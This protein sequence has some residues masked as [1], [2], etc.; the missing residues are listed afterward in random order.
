MD[1]IKAY[2]FIIDMQEPDPDSNVGMTPAKGSFQGGM[3]TTPGR[4]DSSFGGGGGGNSLG[5]SGV[6]LQV[7]SSFMFTLI[8]VCQIIIQ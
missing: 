3:M 1:Q 4:N 8:T 2:V 5:L 7:W 6:Q